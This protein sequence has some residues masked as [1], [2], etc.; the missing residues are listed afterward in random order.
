[1]TAVPW[2]MCVAEFLRHSHHGL[3]FSVPHGRPAHLLW[4]GQV[5][6]TVLPFTLSVTIITNYVNTRLTERVPVSS[7][8]SKRKMQNVANLGIGLSMLLYLI[9]ALFGYLTFYGKSSPFP[10]TT[11]SLR[12][13]GSASFSS[14]R[15]PAFIAHVESELLLGYDMYLPHDMLVMTVRLAILLSVL[16]TVPLIQFPVSTPIAES[17]KW[18]PSPCS[19]SCF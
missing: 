19:S 9:S 10:T 13:L 12:L 3:F 2:L 1:M 7:R 16:L 4:T 18:A 11:L 15:M 17:E 6:S 8:P 14:D 5:R